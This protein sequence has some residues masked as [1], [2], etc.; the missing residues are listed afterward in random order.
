MRNALPPDDD[1]D[2]LHWPWVEMRF[3]CHY[4]ARSAD[5]RLAAL[6]S[7]FGHRV[8]VR[9]LVIRWIDQCAWS[10]R[11]PER[12]PQKYSHKCG[13]YCPD[14]RLPGPPDMAPAMGG[15]VVLEGGKAD[16]LPAEPARE[17]RRRI[18]APDE[19]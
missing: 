5:V 9:S 12:K 4:C 18:G 7:R 11:N 19:S 1:T 16:M 15:L 14:V 17:R 3:R 2:L 8:T 10:P 13:G 6:A